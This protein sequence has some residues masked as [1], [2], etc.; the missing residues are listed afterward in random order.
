MQP[1][2]DSGVPTEQFP[3]NNMIPTVCAGSQNYEHEANDV[4]CLHPS[5]TQT[6]STAGSLP[7]INSA[8]NEDDPTA[9]CSMTLTENEIITINTSCDNDNFEN[10]DRNVEV[11]ET[12]DHGTEENTF[13]DDD[14]MSSSPDIPV[15]TA[16]NTEYQLKYN[17]DDNDEPPVLTPN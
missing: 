3:E 8:N 4:D 15:L 5:R 12:T 9:L 2:S 6:N 7:E 10:V 17:S 13:S 16:E 11:S 1:N 14:M